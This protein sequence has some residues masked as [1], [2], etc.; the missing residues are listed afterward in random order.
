MIFIQLIDLMV[1][2]FYTSTGILSIA[3]SAFPM[4]NATWIMVL[5]WLW[6][7]KCHNNHS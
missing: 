7:P 5:L 2:I 4:F 1:G 3:D 6:K